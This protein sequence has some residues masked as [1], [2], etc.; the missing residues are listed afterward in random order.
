MSPRCSAIGATTSSTACSLA[1]A[2]APRKKKKPRNPLGSRGYIRPVYFVLTSLRA[3]GSLN[4]HGFGGG[5]SSG[6]HFRHAYRG[7]AEPCHFLHGEAFAF[8]GE[9]QDFLAG[10]VVD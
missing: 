7:V 2:S 8:T 10:I 9:A 1:A 5:A 3:A 6:G 4:A